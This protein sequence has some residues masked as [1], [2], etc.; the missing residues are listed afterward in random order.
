MISS[1]ATD[2]GRQI[3]KRN[4]NTELVKDLRWRIRGTV[5]IFFFI[6]RVEFKEDFVVEKSSKTQLPVNI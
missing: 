1:T 4:L 3:N 5:Q 2:L 6:L